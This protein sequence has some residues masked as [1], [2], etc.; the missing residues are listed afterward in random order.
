MGQKMKNKWDKNLDSFVPFFLE[1]QNKW[2]K[3]ILKKSYKKKIKK[4]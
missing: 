2:D 4:L 1:F 3:N